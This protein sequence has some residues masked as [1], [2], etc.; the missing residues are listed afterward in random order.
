MCLLFLDVG[1]GF[2]AY[3]VFL[4]LFFFFAYGH[5]TISPGTL[6]GLT[7]TTYAS[8]YHFSLPLTAYMLSWTGINPL[9][10]SLPWV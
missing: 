4:F 6:S 1:S 10:L 7:P 9:G 3:V 2:T 8:L 5:T